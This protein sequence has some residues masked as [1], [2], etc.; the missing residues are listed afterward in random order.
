AFIGLG[1]NFARAAPDS[2]RIWPAWRNLRLTVQIATKLNKSH[3]INGKVAW[4]L[5]CLSRL[6]RDVQAGGAQTVSTE[7]SISYIHAS[8]GD[9]APAGAL[10]LSEPAIV[11]GIAK[12]TLPPN[13]KV[14]WDAWVGDY[15]LV[16]DAIAET[17][18]QW[19]SGFNQ[20]FREPG[21]FFRGNKARE[22]DFS[23]AVGGKA[24]FF[25]PTAL[26]ATGF[27]DAADVFRLMT[28]RSNDQ[29]NTTVY[30]Y[31]DRFRGI[32]G[33]R[34]VLFIGVADRDRL[35]LREGQIVGLKTVAADGIERRM[36]GLRVT[37]YDIPQ[38]CLGTYYPECNVLIPVSHHAAE[39][40]TP[41]AK[42]VPV[43]IV[44]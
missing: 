31:E 35:R 16:R 42:S 8:F 4:L 37:T 9:K 33:T 32:S 21:G 28:L 36:G 20:R 18:P 5:P 1:G 43:R 40:K 12:A 41:A 44:A 22:R 17:Y 11:A 27:A 2:D 14:D 7:D 39:S 23:E 19:F 38:G 29:F 15:G 30:G 13:P 26:S 34:E 10:L 24:N 25:V 3:L 6:E